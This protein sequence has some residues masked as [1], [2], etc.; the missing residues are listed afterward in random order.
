MDV[1]WRE[2]MNQSDPLIKEVRYVKTQT[3]MPSSLLSQKLS[4]EITS[5]TSL[6]LQI[7][8]LLMCHISVQCTQN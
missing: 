2:F 7:E 5:K 8:N 4:L 6:Y 1:G 3:A